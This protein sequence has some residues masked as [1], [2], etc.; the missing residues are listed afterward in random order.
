MAIG[1]I[2]KLKAEE[3]TKA[4]MKHRQAEVL[5]LPVISVS[6]APYNN[7]NKQTNKNNKCDA[8]M[9]KHHT[10]WLGYVLLWA[11]IV[12]SSC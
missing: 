1:L 5:I 11:R 4:Q 2:V 10:L 7:N 8:N 3:E 12:S 6:T 9:H